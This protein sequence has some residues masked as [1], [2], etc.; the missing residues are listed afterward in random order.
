VL[1][2]FEDDRYV[3]VDG[4]PLFVVYRPNHLPDSRAFAEHW[5]ALAAQEGLPGLYLVGERKAGWR[6]ADH[7]FDADILPPIYQLARPR[8]PGRLGAVLHNRGPRWRPTTIPYEEIARQARPA[9]RLPVPDL[10]VVVSNWDNTP[11]FGA[12][13]LVLE[14][15][16]PALFGEAT[17]SAV[18]AV[19]ELPEDQRIVFVKSWNEWAEGNYLEPDQRH[20]DAYLRAL[21]DVVRQSPPRRPAT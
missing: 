17:R 19:Q 4:R 7:G 21:A 10:P 3:R 15:S 13:G 16:T 6:A 2:A 20:G 9:S 5:R 18:D 12:R 1:P 14:G 8:L 11:R